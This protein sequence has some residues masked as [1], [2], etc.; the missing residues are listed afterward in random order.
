MHLVCN[1]FDQLAFVDLIRQFRDDNTDSLVFSVLLKLGFCP[2]DDFSA[3]RGIGLTDTGPAHNYAFRREIRTFDV[4]HQI[5]ELS[6]R[7]IQNADAGIDYF[8]EIMRRY[9]CCH[10]DSNAAGTVHK[11]VRESGREHTGLF[12][13]L[14][15]VRIPIYRLLVDITEHF[16]GDAGKPCLGITVSCRWVSVNGTKVSVAVHQHIAH[17]EILCQTDHCIID[18]SITVR[19][20][21][22]QHVTDAGSRFFKGLV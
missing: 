4:L 21:V 3:S 5:T 12:T 15:K 8:R 7:I 20:V 11:K 22:T 9:I 18:G 2:D 16:V 6:I 10:A 19:M 14:V 1:I 13:S 17:R